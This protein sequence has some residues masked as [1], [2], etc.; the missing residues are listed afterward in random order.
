MT[1]KANYPTQRPSLL[2][3][4]ERSRTVDPRITFT[5]ASTAMRCNPQGLLESVLANVPRI[6]F[7]PVT[8]RCLGLLIEEART[9]LLTYSEDFSN[10]AWSNAATT[11]GANMVV[12]PDGLLTADKLTEDATNAIHR[13]QRPSSV[14]VTSAVVY[15]ASVYAKAAERSL[16]RLNFNTAFAANAQFDLQAGTVSSTTAGAAAIQSVGNGWFRCSVTGTA[17]TT[18]TT[19]AFFELA[20]IASLS[21]QTYQGDGTSGIYI[22]GAQLE[23][24]AFPTS[25]IP[26]V[27]AQATRAA[28]NVR[29]TGA[30]FS[31]WYRVD[32]GTFLALGI[33]QTVAVNT[34]TAFT[35]SNGTNNDRIAA[36]F[37]AGTTSFVAVNN[38][39]QS[40]GNAGTP[41]LNAPNTVAFTYKVDD[42][43]V[44]LNGGAVV[45]DMSGQLPTSVDRLHIGANGPGTGAYTC[46]HIRR[47]AYWPER[48]P[49]AQLQSL[50]L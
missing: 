25:Y 43:A 44:A 26:T 21:T 27:A 36:L 48:L 31:S 19:T 33:P 9:N 17:A 2:L 16:L 13:L 1:T 32:E 45:A 14:S 5:R 50:T 28:E 46:G 30:N 8:G 47:I 41:T 12:A 15:T 22:W 40:S 34:S 11:V 6:D 35:V 24:G 18:Q 4:F 37:L 42:F 20:T 39:A 38:V 10:A 29:M 7:D 23:A 3:D 49:N